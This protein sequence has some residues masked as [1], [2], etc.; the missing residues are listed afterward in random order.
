M[1]KVLI[2]LMALLILTTCAFGEREKSEM[3]RRILITVN[4][5]T[6]TATLADNRKMNQ[7][8]N[9]VMRLKIS[10]SQ[11]ARRSCCGLMILQQYPLFPICPKR[12]NARAAMT[13]ASFA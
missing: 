8:G 10:S 12:I 7:Q 1:K 5:V 13:L 2:M 3:N 4:G 6:R 11:P 9:D